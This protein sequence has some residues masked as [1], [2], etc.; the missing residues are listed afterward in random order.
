MQQITHPYQPDVLTSTH[1]TLLSQHTCG[2]W[3]FQDL[4]L[5]THAICSSFN[6]K[7]RAKYDNLIFQSQIGSE[8]MN[9]G[10]VKEYDA[11][12]TRMYMCIVCNITVT[13]IIYCIIY[14]FVNVSIYLSIY[15]FIYLSIYLS[16]YLCIHLFVYLSIYLQYLFIHLCMYLFDYWLL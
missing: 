6:D 10:T 1:S 15:L 2:F 11:I 9:V 7:H 16:I 8:W 3:R 13:Y 5:L 4:Q 12:C 14:L